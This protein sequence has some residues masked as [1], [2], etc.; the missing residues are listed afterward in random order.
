[1][2]GQIEL[3]P[4]PVLVTFDDGDRTIAD[5]AAPILSSHGIP[6]VAF[7]VAGVIDKDLPYWWDEVSEFVRSGGV[8][9]DLPTREDALLRQLKQCSD[10]ERMRVLAEL[11]R[12]TPGIHPG[13]APQLRRGDLVAL[14]AM[15]IEVANHTMTHPCLPRCSLDKVRSEIVDGH[16]HLASIL[17]HAPRSFAYPNGDWDARAETVLVELGYSAAFLF[18]HRLAPSTS[19]HPLRISRLRIDANASLDR[20]RIVVSGLHPVIHRLRRIEPT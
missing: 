10:D 4:H 5:I 13:V 12:V 18:D 19:T 6:A 7:V 8:L 3:P 11:R 9:R 2:D 15:G 17:G 1:L 16:T 14:E 20:F